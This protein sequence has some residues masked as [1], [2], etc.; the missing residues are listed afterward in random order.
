LDRYANITTGES[1]TSSISCAQQ[2]L[3]EEVNTD[4]DQQDDDYQFDYSYCEALAFFW[5]KAAKFGRLEIM[6]WAGQQLYH[7]AW[8]LE[9]GYNRSTI[10]SNQPS[11]DNLKFCSG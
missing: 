4:D 8:W 10:G 3:E 2:Y 11:T 5:Y 9:P 7:A 1:V 6:R